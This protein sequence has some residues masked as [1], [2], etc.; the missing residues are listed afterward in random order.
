V[1]LGVP[2][3]L[4]RDIVKQ[5]HE[6]VSHGAENKVRAALGLAP[7]PRRIEVDPC[8]DCNGVH[9]GRC[10]GKQVAVRPV[11]QRRLPQRIIEYTVNQLAWSIRGRVEI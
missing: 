9:T 4:I 10:N 7:L 11:R 5:R 2:Y 1:R 8:P 3:T 6:H